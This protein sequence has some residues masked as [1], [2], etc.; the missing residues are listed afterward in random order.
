[1]FDHRITR[2]RFLGT[3]A[4]ALATTAV[5]F[6]PVFSAE[7]DTLTV[8]VTADIGN[9]DPAFWQNIGDLWTIDSIHPKLIIFKPGNKYEWELYGAEMIEAVDA[10]NIKFKLRPGM[11]WTNG[12]GEVTTED[13]KYSFERY[14]DEELASP[15]AGNWALLDRVDIE[16]KYTGTIV[17]NKPFSPVWWYVLPYASGG[18]VCKV[19][20]EE[21]GGK[22][23]LDPPATA[24]PYKLTEY[25][26]QQRIVLEAHDGWNGPK[27]EFT[28]IVMLPIVDSKAAE[29]GLETGEIEFSRISASSV[30]SYLQNM[31]SGLKMDVR[32]SPSYFWLGLNVQ[33][34]KLADEAVRRAII[35]VVDVDAILEGA[36]FGVAERATGMASKGLLGYRETTPEPRD[37]EGAKKLMSDAGV[38]ELS[39]DLEVVAETDR[40]TAAQI[41][42]ANLAEIGID[43]QINS[44]DQGAFWSLGDEKGKDLQLQLKQFTSPPDMSWSTQWFLPEQAGIWN[45]EYLDSPQFVDLHYAAMQEIDLEKRHELLVEI[46]DVMDASAGY[47]WITN[48]PIP[49]MWSKQIVPAMKPNGDP[50]FEL[51]RKA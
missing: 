36:F 12:Y 49:V 24:G 1:M 16:D 43:L 48:P 7:G 11:M 6:N 40:L 18:I 45:W 22:F 38:S 10:Q 42:Q 17:F 30:P 4:A 39:L 21:V 33:H 20:V 2:R 28:K 51:F 13:V 37:V 34:P 41:I 46:Q 32:P 29:R 26:A 19:A 14:L 31:P 9:L 23:T 15:I 8:R 50:R 27:P 25:A 35:K 44:H 5:P 3:S 47:L